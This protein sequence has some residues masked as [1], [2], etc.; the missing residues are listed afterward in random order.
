MKNIALSLFLICFGVQISVSQNSRINNHNSIGWYGYFGS[1]KL[2]KKFSVTTEYQYRRNNVISNL[3]QNLL[4][5]GVGYQISPKVQFR[6]GYAWI[7]THPYGEIPIN[8]FGKDFTEH[9]AFQMITMSDKVSLLELSHRFM[10]EQRWVGR[11]STAT[12]LTE[13]LF[14]LLNRIRYMLRMQI[15]LKG[16]TIGDHTPYLAVYDEILIG[17][18]RNV[19]ENVFDQNRLGIVFGYKVDNTIRLEAGFLNQILQL[20]REVNGQNVFQNNTGLIVNAN[21]NFDLSRK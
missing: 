16:K 12:M 11:Y 4:R 9:R 3:K 17:F 8:G 15:P 2:D 18:G 10:L 5:L 6:V 13:D 21:F 1:F 20:G 14:P 7:E 19:N